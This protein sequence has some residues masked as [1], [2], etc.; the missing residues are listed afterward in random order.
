VKNTISVSV[1]ILRHK[2]GSYLISLRK[3]ALSF[4]GLWEFP[5]GKI[6]HGE[7]PIQALKRELYEEVGVKIGTNFLPIIHFTHEYSDVIVDLHAYSIDDWEGSPNSCEGQKLRWVTQEELIDTQ[8]PDANRAIKLALTLPNLSLIT[9]DF[10]GDESSYLKQLK[11]CLNRG[12]KLV[13]LR[14]PGSSTACITSIAKGA[15]A[16]CKI[17]QAKL[18]INNESSLVQRLGA[19]GLHLPSSILRGLSERPV[20]KVFLL[21]TSCHNRSEVEHANKLGVDFGYISP[22]EHP[23]SHKSQ[24]ILGWE[25]ASELAKLADFP[26]FALGGLNKNDI[27]R[28]GQL[29]FQGVSMVTALWKE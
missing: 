24:S 26:V 7:Q 17:H 9:P 8:M 2:N 28:S 6:E 23:S 4:P 10:Y 15:L 20:E 1:G 11:I 18:L 29:G 3:K 22:V 16:M 14:M 13:Q 25:S 21:S 27:Q 5:G 12:V 19:D